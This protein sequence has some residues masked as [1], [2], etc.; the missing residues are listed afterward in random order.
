MKVPHPLINDYLLWFWAS[1]D[2]VLKWYCTWALMFMATSSAVAPKHLGINVQAYNQ[3]DMLLLLIRFP[4]LEV[5]WD[6]CPVD[7]QNQRNTII[8]FFNFYA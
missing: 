1:D 2:I 4:G 6:W 8:V 3:C 7:E 5:S